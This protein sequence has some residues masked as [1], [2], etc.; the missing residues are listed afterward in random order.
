MP[1]YTADVDALGTLRLLNAIRMCSLERSCRL[2]QA[3]TSE[4]YG[5]V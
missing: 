2:Y 1:E 3:S 4:L 5:K